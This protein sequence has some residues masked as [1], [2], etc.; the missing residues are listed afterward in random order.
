MSHELAAF[1]DIYESDVELVSVQTHTAEHA[2]DPTLL[3]GHHINE[4][5]TQSAGDREVIA[6][7]VNKTLNPAST[8]PLVDQI[9]A[10]TDL[11]EEL[12]GCNA[13]GIRIATLNGP[14][15]PKFHVDQ[16]PCRLLITLLGPGTE[17]ICDD[18][19]DRTALA[20]RAVDI[21]PVRE[22]GAVQHLES[23]SWSLLKGGTWDDD[24][25][26]GVVH[27]SPHYAGDRLLISID[28]MFVDPAA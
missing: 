3:A 11:L 14:M 17:W 5:W 6:E 27:R 15:C 12:L 16:V 2:V 21:V 9:G 24:T 28:P 19:A 26:D 4:K 1:A 22:T 23:G 7:H 13:V 8:G 10:A 25:F 20:N 18:D